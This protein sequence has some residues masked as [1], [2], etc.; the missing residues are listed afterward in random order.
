MGIARRGWGM[1]AIEVPGKFPFAGFVGLN[2][3][4]I[5]VDWMPQVEI[6][7]RLSREAWHAGYATEGATAAMQFA[8]D[9]LKL[10]QVVAMSVTTNTPSH[11]VMERLG[12]TQDVR[13]D[14][15]HPAVPADWPL[16]RHFLHRLHH[17]EWQQ[18]QQSA[19]A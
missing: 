8:F 3:P 6:G 1:W 2:V 12:M 15:D 7:W 17:A 13:A 10:A 19:V 5:D 4:G 14:F 18:R 16:K 11:K 9:E